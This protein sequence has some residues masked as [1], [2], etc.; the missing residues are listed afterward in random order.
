MEL[1]MYF[2]SSYEHSLVN[3]NFPAACEDIRSKYPVHKK[4][5]KNYNVVLFVKGYL[6]EDTP[7]FHLDSILF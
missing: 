2:C 5:Y 6:Q 7:R 4:T 1:K 3:A